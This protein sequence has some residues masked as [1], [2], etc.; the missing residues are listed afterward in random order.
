MTGFKEIRPGVYEPDDYIPPK[1]SEK[2]DR[3]NLVEIM[4]R[5]LDR[6]CA[7]DVA[8]STARMTLDRS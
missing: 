3:R 6:P 7:I 4:D 2:V 1:D 8:R 5:M